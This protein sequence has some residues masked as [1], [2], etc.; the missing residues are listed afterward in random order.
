MLKYFLI[1]TVCGLNLQIFAQTEMKKISIGL[2]AAGDVLIT[3]SKS[4]GKKAPDKIE[5]LTV[6]TARDRESVYGVPISDKDKN[7]TIRVSG[8][9][10]KATGDLGISGGN[11]VVRI[12][13]I[14]LSADKILTVNLQTDGN[15]IEYV[16]N[17][18]E[19][20]PGFS[21]ALDPA[22]AA[23][24][25][26][27]FKLKRTKL[28]ARKKITVSL[29]AANGTINFADNAL[30]GSYSLEITKINAD[31]SEDSFSSPEVSSKK[32]NRFQ[33]DFKNL[34]EVCLRIDD[35]GKG[36]ADEKCNRLKPL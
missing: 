19:E 5:G 4:P 36:F 22:E 28:P 24:P 1:L 20:N 6:S 29:D 8:T 18:I 33:L 10:E 15:K 11:F 21:F 30:S 27:I 26:Y 34:K 14:A 23:Q 35:D 25:S 2:N 3:K 32:A 9:K 16:S 7:L 12:L 17:K 31:G 13:G